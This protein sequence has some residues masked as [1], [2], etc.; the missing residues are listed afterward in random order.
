MGA[1]EYDREC[2]F[3]DGTAASDAG[4]GWRCS[5]PGDPNSARIAASSSSS[6]LISFTLQDHNHH[7]TFTSTV[8]AIAG[9]GN[10]AR[11]D[12]RIEGCSNCARSLGGLVTQLQ[13]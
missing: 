10:T 9:M 2:F 3:P 7:H 8:T 4:S 1:A 6:I 5:G 11:A 12:M 13:S